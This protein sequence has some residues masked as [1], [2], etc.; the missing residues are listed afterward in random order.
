MITVEGT[1][2]ANKR[3]KKLTFKNSAPFRTCIFIKNTSINN[4]ED[5]DIVINV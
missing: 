3:N 2:N 1:V 5:L 4:A